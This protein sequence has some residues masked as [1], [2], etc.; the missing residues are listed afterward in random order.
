MYLK[1]TSTL[2]QLKTLSRMYLQHLSPF[3]LTILAKITTEKLYKDFHDLRFNCTHLFIYTE[4]EK[5]WNTLISLKP[6]NVQSWNTQNMFWDMQ[7]KIVYEDS[8]FIHFGKGVF[9]FKY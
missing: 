9:G 8:N 1:L 2:G 5:Y 6:I 7:T 3:T 4:S